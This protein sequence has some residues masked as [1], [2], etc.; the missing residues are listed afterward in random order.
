MACRVIALSNFYILSYLYFVNQQV[1][2]A[3]RDHRV[4]LEYREIKEKQEIRA[5]EAFLDHQVRSDKKKL[6]L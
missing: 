5:Q 6:S 1:L 4:Y 3:K 2:K